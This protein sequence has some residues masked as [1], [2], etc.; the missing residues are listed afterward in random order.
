LPLL[1]RALL[2]PAP[3]RPDDPEGRAMARPLLPLGA[4]RTLGELCMLRAGLL[5]RGAPM[6]GEERGAS[7]RGAVLRGAGRG[8]ESIR[9]ALRGSTRG[10]LGR[11]AS[12]R[13]PLESGAVTRG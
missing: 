2:P 11:G 7:M 12:G 4:L 5:A 3:P 6:R 10:A 9:G 13:G 8:V 1:D